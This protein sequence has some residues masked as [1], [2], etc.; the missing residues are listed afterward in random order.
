MDNFISTLV[1]IFVGGAVTLW[2]SRHYYVKTGKDLEDAAAG[3]QRLTTQAHGLANAAVGHARVGGR[4]RGE[5]SS[6]P[7]GKRL[8]ARAQRGG[9]LLH[10]VLH[11][12]GPVPHLTE[13]PV[14]PAE[15]A[16]AAMPHLR[17]HRAEAHWC[18]GD[19]SI[20]PGRHPRLH[21]SGHQDGSKGDQDCAAGT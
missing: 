11:G 1:G 10:P 3:L 4:G 7:T 20:S 12:L 8:Q 16:V 14:D 13:M 6:L 21:P 17:P 19:Q 9:V 2:V 5:L 18:A 15:Q